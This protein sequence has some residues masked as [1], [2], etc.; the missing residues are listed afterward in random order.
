MS[1]V[2]ARAAAD[3][4][5]SIEGR[6]GAPVPV[7]G[8]HAAGRAQQSRSRNGAGLDGLAQVDIQEVLFGHRT[9]GGRAGRQVTP[10]IPH[11]AERLPRDWLAHLARL[12]AIPGYDRR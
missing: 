6:D 10:K 11:R 9:Q 8:R 2:L 5:D 4:I 3:L 12:V 1:E 7:A